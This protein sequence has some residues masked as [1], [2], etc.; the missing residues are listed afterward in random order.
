MDVFEIII[1]IVGIIADICILFLTGMTAYFT[2]FSKKIVV[3]SRGFS[4]SIFDGITIELTIENKTLRTIPVSAIY[5]LYKINDKW[6]STSV[7][8]FDSPTLIGSK[9]IRKI[10]T[11]AFTSISNIQDYSDFVRKSIIVVM[12]GNDYIWTEKNKDIEH[13]KKL[14]NNHEIENLTIFRSEYNGII[15]TDNVKYIV[16][17]REAINGVYSY[18]TVFVSK[19]G[20]LNKSIKGVNNISLN[21][22]ID[23]KIISDFLINYINLTKDDFIIEKRNK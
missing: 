5:F 13:L 23:E 8:D 11:K 21:G 20:L 22:K 15:L 9:E 2:M 3:P 16:N 7:F 4:N 18:Q 10:Q 12:S 1:G 19:I 14:F 17:Y 6:F